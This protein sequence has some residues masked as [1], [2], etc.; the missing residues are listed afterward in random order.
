MRFAVL[1]VGANSV[2]L[3]VMDARRGEPL[4]RVFSYKTDLRL[5]ENVDERKRVTEA[6]AR[7][8]ERLVAEADRRQAALGCEAMAAVATSSLREAGNG[9]DVVERVRARTGVE[10]TVLTGPDEAGLTFLAVRRW[11]G[12][13]AGRLLALDLGG[14]S[15]EI[16]IGEGEEPDHAVSLPLGAGRLTRER[17]TGDP[18]APDQVAA[19][20][21]QVLRRAPFDLV[22]ATSKTF[23]QLARLCGAAPASAGPYV[24]RTLAREDLRARIPELA[25]TSSAQRATLRGVSRSRA[26][27]ILAGALVAEA[28]LDVLEIAEVRLCPWA[29]REG[30]VLRSLDALASGP[31][32]RLPWPVTRR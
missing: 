5:A 25:R 16:A 2:H 14:G 18:P 12:W 7:D 10:L 22:A 11:F 29:L 26:P 31:E 28:A 32:I 21:A 20:R 17:L 23:R 6:G 19:L 9:R 24:V 15:M 13:S 27:Q 3:V 4:A 30:V 8:L 1:D